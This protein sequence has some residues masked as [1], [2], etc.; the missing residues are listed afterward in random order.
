[1][2]TASKIILKYELPEGLEF[3]NM[4]THADKNNYWDYTRLYFFFKS[5]LALKKDD[6][7][8]NIR[9]LTLYRKGFY[10]YTS[11]KEYK[12]LSEW[13][14]DNGKMLDDIVYGI[15][16]DM[17][18]YSYSTREYVSTR[19]IA[20]IPLM[21]L[22]NYLEPS[23]IGEPEPVNKRLTIFEFNELLYQLDAIRNKVE[24]MKMRL[25]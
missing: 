20:F 8:K 2:D 9:H 15:N 5:E 6:E 19:K 25:D 13:A 1:M 14:I 7:K 17:R 3:V 21:Q 4:S 22:L 12:S 18:E 23:Y 11:K 10:D 24:D 16:R